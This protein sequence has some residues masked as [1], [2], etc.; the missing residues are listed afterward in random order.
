MN[1]YIKQIDGL[2]FLSII[3]V[4]ISHWLHPIDGIEKLRL[5]ISG[6]EI[7]FV[8]SGF[9]ITAQLLGLK[10]KVENGS[11]TPLKGLC[12]FYWRRFF[13]IVPLYYLVLLVSTLLNK[14]EIRQAFI[15]NFSFFSNFYFIKQQSWGANFSQFWSLA[16]EMQ[17]YAL[18]PL[19][20]LF[21]KRHYLPLLFLIITIITLLFRFFNYID[22]ANF[23]IETIHTISCLDLFMAGSFM[24]YFKKYKSIIYFKIISNKFLKLLIFIL[25]IFLY[26][27][28]VKTN[29]IT[30]YS[31]VFQRLLFAFVFSFL[32]AYLSLDLNDTVNILIGNSFMTNLGKLSYS[33]Y[34]IHN[35][36]P[37]ILLPIQQL[38]FPI[39]FEFLIYF[40][41]TLITSYLLYR[42]YEN[43]IRN[44]A[45]N[46]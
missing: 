26:T 4:L 42:F 20:I 8:I 36:I 12:D 22:N 14:G 13:R 41:S 39:M 34:L 28:L 11:I 7:F 23:F 9:L 46:Q 38:K 16:V 31:F 18:W 43:P 37:G 2:R 15:W 17:F 10:N 3:L 45:K 27:L 1:S 25:F 40:I 44:F 19:F 5:G 29:G 24:A 6:V 21:I 33:I 30:L 32:I 35:F